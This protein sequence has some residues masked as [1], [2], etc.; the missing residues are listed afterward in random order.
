MLKFLKHCCKYLID[1]E[2]AAFVVFAVL[3]V[4]NILVEV[5]VSVEV[6]G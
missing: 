2:A 4:F 5:V 1:V 3:D 6:E